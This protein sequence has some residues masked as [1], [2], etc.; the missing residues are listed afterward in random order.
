MGNPDSDSSHW[1]HLQKGR[2]FSR[3]LYPNPV[4]FLSTIN[5]NN[6]GVVENTRSNVM[7]LSWITP[8]NN[9][10]RFMFSINKNRYSASLLAPPAEERHQKRKH[11]QTK[12][13]DDEP[14]H[15]AEH[16]ANNY[17]AGIEFALSV[18]V[19]GMEQV[20]LDVGSISGRVGSKFPS[21]RDSEHG[22]ANEETNLSNRKRKKLRMEQLSLHGVDGLIPVPL[23]GPTPDTSSGLSSAPPL[24]AIKGTVAHLKCRT[25]AVIGSSKS[26]GE[27]ADSANCAEAH[28]DHD[29]LLVMA[30]VIDGYVHPS[31]WDDKKFMFRPLSKDVPP[32]LTF[33]GSQ[34]FGY[35]VSGDYEHIG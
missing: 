15:D 18:P 14:E 11:A 35:V 27:T 32:Y 13:S 20:V 33:F 22:V 17:Q 19:Q 24:F 34:T 30:K 12:S 8:T 3:V 4:C 25:Y 5:T 29:H 21:S 7:T 2:E 26:E 28:I 10:G 23:G 6:D 1:I 9:S 16:D 31:Y